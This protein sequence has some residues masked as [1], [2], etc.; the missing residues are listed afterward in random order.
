G[1]DAAASP[2]SATTFATGE[3]LESDSAAAD[4]SAEA[5]AGFWAGQTATTP[6]KYPALSHAKRDVSTT[7]DT[8]VSKSKLK[9]RF[10]MPSKA[11]SAATNR[12]PK[13]NTSGSAM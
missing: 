4:F 7:C 11:A 2:G 8:I 1:S 12:A 6:R 9:T 3:S 10:T 13:I 5:A